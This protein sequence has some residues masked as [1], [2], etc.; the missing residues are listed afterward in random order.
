MDGEGPWRV[1]LYD[2]TRIVQALRFV[3]AWLP[4]DD[5]CSLPCVRLDALNRRGR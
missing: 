1:I 5:V 2:P 4:V 3:R